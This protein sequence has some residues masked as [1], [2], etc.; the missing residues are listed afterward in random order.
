MDAAIPRRQV[1]QAVM[2]SS[3][4]I[5]VIERGESLVRR[6]TR[7]LILRRGVMAVTCVVLAATTAMAQQSVGTVTE[8]VSTRRDLNGR[9]GLSEKLVTH[10]ARTNDEER[11]V[12]ETYSPS[13][14]AGRLALSQRI[15]RVTTATDDGSRTV[16]E[17][18]ERNPAA[19]NEPLR[20]V[21]RTVTTVRRSGT[22]SYVTER[23]VFERDVNGR[24]VLV[25]KQTESS[26]SN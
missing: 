9:D 3:G 4:R 6:P 11:V 15:N 8:T 5:Q 22:D 10:R 17:A 21:Q 7:R 24:L 16:E 25:H 12:I 18:A 26:F 1:Q 13:T 19:S 2:F 20:I 14:E 23:Q